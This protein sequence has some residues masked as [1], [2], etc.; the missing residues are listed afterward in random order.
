ML[1]CDKDV[2]EVKEYMKFGEFIFTSP[3]D[4]EEFYLVPYGHYGETSTPF[5]EV[6]KNG[7]LTRTVNA[8]AIA[9]VRFLN[10]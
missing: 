6:Y 4:G 7:N 1:G 2:K 9:E 10:T 8:S 5:I 3:R